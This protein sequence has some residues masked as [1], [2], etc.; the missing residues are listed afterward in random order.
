MTENNKEWDINLKFTNFVINTTTNRTTGYS[1]F[2]L[3]FGRNPNIP[4][5]I[6]TSTSLTHE[7]LIRKWKKKHEENIQKAKERIQLVRKN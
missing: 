7:S 1:P 6:S 4:S 5:E 3:K 2:E